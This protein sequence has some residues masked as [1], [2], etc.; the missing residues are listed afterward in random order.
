[1]KTLS[2]HVFFVLL[3]ITFFSQVKA[4]N[5][6]HIALLNENIFAPSN[7]II[8]LNIWNTKFPDEIKVLNNLVE[9]YKNENVVF[10]AITDEDEDIVQLFLKTQPFNYQ[11]LNGA[12][13]EEIYNN[14]QTGMYKVYP[15]HIIIDQEGKISY[16]RKN[17]LKNI[18]AKLVKRIDL[19]LAH[20]FKKELPK[21][22]EVYT[23]N[24]NTG[25]D[26]NL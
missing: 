3:I 17:A 25:E 8:V 23:F 15:M 5:Q 20:N 16:K 26:P 7:K 19:L 11:H 4:Q 1:M 14:F 24:K 18:E 10:V 22:T 13:G 2:P 9:K 12:E 6:D 21:S